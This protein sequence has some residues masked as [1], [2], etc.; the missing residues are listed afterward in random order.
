MTVPAGALDTLLRVLPSAESGTVLALQAL[1]F[2]T[3][4]IVGRY[5]RDLY[6]G[7][8]IHTL[9]R[10]YSGAF[11]VVNCEMWHPTDNC[12]MTQKV[13]YALP[14]V[15]HET[16]K[17]SSSSLSSSAEGQAQPPGG[18]TI[19]PSTEGRFNPPAHTLA[20]ASSST[21]A[22]TK[23]PAKFN[24]TRHAFK[25]VRNHASGRYG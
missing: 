3:K 17:S 4:A 16:L 6:P 1:D 9:Q 18:V 22:T 25:I 19:E 8:S 24:P 11:V 15:V 2:K 23:P 20:P 13:L 10:Q 5:W 21:V 14:P 12:L 7:L